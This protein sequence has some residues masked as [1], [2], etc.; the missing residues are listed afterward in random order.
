MVAEVMVLPLTRALALAELLTS[1]IVTSM[2]CTTYALDDTHVMDAPTMN[3]ATD[4][5]ITETLLSATDIGPV[6]ATFPLFTTM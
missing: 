2:A 1:P 6:S 3:A 5:Q 4:G